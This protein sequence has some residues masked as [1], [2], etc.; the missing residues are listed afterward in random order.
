[1][2]R[3]GPTINSVPPVDSRAVARAN[4]RAQLNPWLAVLSGDVP[5]SSRTTSA[6]PYHVLHCI[7]AGKA[8]LPLLA[9][10]LRGSAEILEGHGGPSSPVLPPELFRQIADQLDL[11]AAPPRGRPTSA[12]HDLARFALAMRVRR[13]TRVLRTR[14]RLSG[15]IS[16]ARRFKT[17]A[18]RMKQWGVGPQSP[19][20]A[21]LGIVARETGIT[22]ETLRG[23]VK[24]HNLARYTSAEGDYGISEQAVRRYF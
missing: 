2:V 20:E 9:G 16:G 6:D 19:Q 14:Y 1:M 18:R 10:A 7:R 11:L 3:R 17:V 23:Y 4:T 15:G 5:V 8:D 13:W 21:A 24:D 12:L 22:E